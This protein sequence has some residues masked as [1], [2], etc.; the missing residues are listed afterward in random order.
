MADTL[1][2][3]VPESPDSLPEFPMPRQARCPFDPPP[4]LK[5]LQE[6][7]PL[8]K[9]RLWD[10]SEPWLVTKYADQ[11]ALLGDPRVSADTDSPG[12]PTKA[13]PEGGEGK[14][15]FIM[16]DDPEHARLRR[17]VTAPFA[18]KRVE[19]LR[20]A[21]QK[22]VDDLIDGMLGRPGPVDLV[23]EFAL[24]IPS[25][26]ICELLGVPYDD[27]AFFQDNTK[28]MVHRDAT[29]EQRGQASR[30]V[31]GYL[32]T[33]IGKRLAEP[34]DDLL[35]GIAGRV[36]AGEIDHRQ[37]TEMALLLL[38]AGHETTANMIALGTLALL[39]NPDQLA[40]LRESDDPK[41]VAG[42][43]EE[44]LRYL[45]ITHLGR[46]RAVTEDIEIGGRLVRAGE[47]VIMA[48]EIANRDPEVFPDP[49]RLDL[50]RD[51]R[52]HVAFG[53]GVHQCLGQPLA[54]ME[55][56]VVYGTLY[57]RIPTLKL[58]C[59]LEDVRFKNDA[60]I[61]GVHELPVSW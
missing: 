48:N 6:K 1:A 27:H 52:R 34:R 45:H 42:A 40:L 13:S 15:S 17:M 29:P 19:A 5:D 36:T 3:P 49:D 57:K 46:R 24:P 16:M 9:V 12:Y 53:F 61:Y 39:Q 37:A 50:T 20:P 14:L 7:A 55:L 47:G 33:L 35:S 43:V 10:G 59:A 60:F 23:E 11:R 18:I 38:I 28:T 54:R 58:A 30:E 2:G 22:I 21:V 44:L 31:A 51:A 25:L 56:Q 8:T 32:A 41:F 4:A 26:V